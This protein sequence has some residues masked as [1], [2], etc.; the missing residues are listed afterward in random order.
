MKIK[1][2]LRH[3][4]SSASHKRPSCL[5]VIDVDGL[6]RDVFR[7]ALEAGDLPNVERI[8]GGWVGETA[9]HMDAL[10][11]APSI[12]F[13][14]QASIFTGQHPGV[15]GI[16][17]NE[18]FDR[19]G[20]ISS[21]RPRHFGFDVGYTLAVD[22]A[23]LVFTD[24]LASQF[25]S[26]ET[27]TLYE[28]ASACGLT[29][30]VVYHMYAR[31]ADVW[32]PPNVVEIA[33]FTKGG[34]VLGLEAPEY[35][36]GMLDRLI[37]HLDAG[38]RPDVLTAYF[39]G[40]DHHSHVHGP[41]SQPA[42]LRDV[43]DPQVG[44][45]L[46]VLETRGMLGGTLFA[47][48]SDHGQIEV[49]PDDRHSI[50]LGFPFDRELGHVFE[51]LG[52]DVHDVPGE[53]PAC[54]A[55]MGLNGGLAHVYLQHR[56]GRWADPPR[57]EEDVLPVAESFRQMNET[58][59]YEDELQGSLELILVRDAEHEGWQGEYRVYLGDGRTQPLA[60]HLAA[61]P[62]LDYADAANRIRL[63]ASVTTG[64][65]ILV[66]NGREGYYFGA[67]TTGVHGGLYPEESEAVLTFAYPDGSPDEIGWL[68]ETVTGVVTDRCANEGGRE[69]SVADMV[70]IAL[71]LL[72]LSG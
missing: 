43:I 50:R 33:R 35:D 20:R 71:V 42:Y 7:A 60:D 52:L 25:L 63:A 53:D 8:V 69:P 18:S 5:V 47:L 59:K 49:V 2:D 13:A 62:G 57:Y 11:T 64:D 27:P 41:A 31:G 45:L 21:G 10:S 67:P 48:V 29:S 32:L 34:G 54:D 9:C 58:G 30:A 46:D 65:L 17:G 61:H 14:A 24:G 23:V 39:M 56:A 68:R 38:G 4:R 37:K 3:L 55:V 36:G 6:R 70:P 51:A 19:L 44:R 22:D 12:T 15:H 40:L 72:G 66:A 26:G 16:A 28:M 1:Q